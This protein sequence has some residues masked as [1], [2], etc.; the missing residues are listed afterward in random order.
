M[1]N[2]NSAFYTL[3][4]VNF[5]GLVVILLFFGYR[6]YDSSFDDAE[7][8]EIQSPQSSLNQ[9]S[10]SVIQ[11]IITDKVIQEPIEKVAVA[12]PKPKP[13]PTKTL[14]TLYPDDS[15]A[16]PALTTMELNSEI[17]VYNAGPEW[18][19]V[20]SEK[21]VPVWIRG[22]L[23]KNVAS[24]YVEIIIASVNARSE[25]NTESSAVIGSLAKGEVLKV[26][27]KK[28]GWVRAW[29]PVRFLTWVKTED[30][31]QR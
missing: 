13:V 28:D 14:I 29:S 1:K 19:Q 30:L 31:E 6:Y 8:A 3:S 26:S 27:R 25:P 17:A 2:I 7:L 24:G 10:K 20:I 11:P 9:P 23:V 18:T 22:D 4:V 15:D 12:E 16:Y 5:L 21:G